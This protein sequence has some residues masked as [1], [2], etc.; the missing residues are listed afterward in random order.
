MFTG[1]N[2]NPDVRSGYRGLNFFLKFFAVKPVLPILLCLSALFLWPAC[3]RRLEPTRTS[4]IPP[5]VYE[6]VDR[7]FRAVSGKGARNW[8]DLRS[9]CLP[10]C[11]FNGM[12][13][14]E[15]G[16]SVFVPSN[17]EGYIDHL[18]PYLKKE[19]FYQ[20]ALLKKADQYR[21]VA[22]VWCAF[23]SRNAPEGPVIDQGRIGF[24]LVQVQG[25]W[26][27]AAVLWNSEP[28]RD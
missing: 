8:Q 22:Q 13:V 28:K 5:A 6:T 20:K 21:Q 16:A 18:D 1:K 25:D 10:T 27:I 9:L 2:L 14:N 11:Q 15:R 4:T 24:Q 26:K 17:L 7:Y 3:T 12:G 23:E 19:G